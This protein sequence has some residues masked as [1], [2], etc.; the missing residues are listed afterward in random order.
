[1]ISKTLNKITV[2]QR[3][4]YDFFFYDFTV[5]Q[6]LVTYGTACTAIDYRSDVK[7]CYL[8]FFKITFDFSRT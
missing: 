5:S 4:S 7:I 1:M 3:D 8:A 6:N 2:P